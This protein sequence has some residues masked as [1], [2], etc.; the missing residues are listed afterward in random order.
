MRPDILIFCD[1]G[2]GNRINA[3]ASGLAVARY[4]GLTYCVHWPINNW[5]AAP[6]KKI[7]ANRLNV[8]TE[9]I[10]QL[11]GKLDDAVMLLHDEIASS[12]LKVN[13]ESAYRFK[14]LKDFATLPELKFK[15]IF[16]YPAVIPSWVPMELVHNELKFLKFDPYI[17]NEAKEFINNSMPGSFYGLHLRRTDLNVGMNDQEVFNLA[18]AHPEVTFFV[19]SDDPQA[20]RLAAGHPN[21]LRREKKFQVE[22]K[23]IDSEWLEKTHDDDGRPYFSNIQRNEKAVIEGAI[24]LLILGHSQIVGYSGST[25]QSVAKLIGENIRIKN[26]KFEKIINYYSITTIIKGIQNKNLNAEEIIKISENQAISQGV[27]SGIDIIEAS[28]EYFENEELCNLLLYL[29]ILYI[30]QNKINMAII[31][32]G[33]LNEVNYRNQSINIKL[34]YAHFLK[35][36]IKKTKEFYEKI[37]IPHNFDNNDNLIYQYLEKLFK[38]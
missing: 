32:L 7:F 18:K 26:I 14:D 6:F 13:F 34:A 29:S 5:C 11:R 12:T 21:V 3:L 25:F 10:S 17:I 22:K 9:S 16:Y 36:N 33:K 27:S 19:C 2:L 20:E 8:S 28:I 37:E 24:D 30:N 31:I 4:F 35:K 23:T 15:T 38:T 1:G